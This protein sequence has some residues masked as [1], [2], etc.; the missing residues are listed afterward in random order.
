MEEIAAE[1]I[2]TARATAR[3]FLNG[4]EAPLEQKAFNETEPAKVEIPEPK[5][6]AFP[7]FDVAKLDLALRELPPGDREK[8]SLAAT[9]LI[10]ARRDE[11]ERLAL[12]ARAEL[13]VIMQRLS[14]LESA[15]PNFAVAIEALA[16]ELALAFSGNLD[17]FHVMPILLFGGAGVGKT[18]FAT[19]LAQ[20]FNVPFEKISMGSASSNFELAGVSR[21]WS[22]ARPGRIAKLLSNSQDA[23]PV[24][25]LDEIDKIGNDS[26]YPVEPVLLDLLEEDSARHFR[27]EF[28]EVNLDASR[29]I[30]V[31]TA[32]DPERLSEPLRS[33]VRMIEIQP[34]TSD[35]R[36][37]IVGR[38]VGQ[39]RHTYGIEFLP[40]AESALS[41]PD[42]D[43]RRLQ[44]MLR[45]ATGRAL[46]QGR[47]VCPDDLLMPEKKQRRMG[48]I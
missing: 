4:E 16:V 22:T 7:I 42:F 45:D 32:N 41:A 14:D 38:L 21:G 19:Q 3:D 48:F 2:E 47:A 23:S 26:R 9:S 18:L 29:I 20:C 17:R 39:Y 27:D 8:S 5:L 30:F 13:S 33:R 37:E 15:M 10:A 34:P 12:P 43:L 36:R 6:P 35:Q 1:A 46:M 24:V 31:A 44:Q 25:L 11:G 28:L 40:E